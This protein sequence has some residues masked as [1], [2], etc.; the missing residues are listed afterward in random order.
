M[1]LSHKHRFIFLHCRKTAGSS[2]TVSL[3]RLLGDDDI[4]VGCIV[5]G[6]QSG[7]RPPKGMIRGAMLSPHLPPAL[8]LIRKLSFWEYVNAWSKYH[9]RSELGGK[10]SHTTAA[11]IRASFPREWETYT[12]FCAIRNPWDK[13]VSDYYWRTKGRPGSPT[14]AQYVAALESGDRLGGVVPEVHSNWG[15]Y[16]IDDQVAVDRVLRYETLTEDLRDL[17][18]ELGVEWDGWLP[19]AKRQTGTAQRPSDYRSVYTDREIETV[20]RLYDREIRLG[21]YRFA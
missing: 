2:V 15:I 20:A 3:S 9:Y 6:A 11:D 5:D 19:R 4:Q 21:G 10:G 13:T 7:V 12:S 8:M 17:M 14:F 18:R 1:I 16:T